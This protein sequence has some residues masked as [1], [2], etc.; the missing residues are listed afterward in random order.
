MQLVIVIIIIIIIMLIIIIKIIMIIQFLS[1][2][3]TIQNGKFYSK[4]SMWV[5]RIIMN[6]TLFFHLTK[7]LIPC[8]RLVHVKLRVP[9]TLKLFPTFMEHNV[10]LP[11]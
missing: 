8:G 5:L 4:Q 3:E 1:V 7:S 9:Q 11:H 6:I 10:S 2:I